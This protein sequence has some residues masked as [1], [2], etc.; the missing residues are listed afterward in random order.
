[1]PGI[2]GKVLVFVWIPGYGYRW[3]VI[4]TSLEVNAGPNEPQPKS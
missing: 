4:D 3:T 2:S 1:M